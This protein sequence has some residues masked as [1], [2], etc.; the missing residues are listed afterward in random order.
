MYGADLALMASDFADTGTTLAM[1]CVMGAGH[2]SETLSTAIQL[3][4]PQLIIYVNHGELASNPIV[5]GDLS[6]SIVDNVCTY[7]SMT[8]VIHTEP[9]PPLSANSTDSLLKVHKALQVARKCL[10][11]ASILRA[12]SQFSMAI[13][14]SAK[15]QK[16]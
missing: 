11:S 15:R 2:A 7:R 9:S 13:S 16:L 14:L 4:L 6:M 5:S 3:N 8:P 12:V 1:L 10:L